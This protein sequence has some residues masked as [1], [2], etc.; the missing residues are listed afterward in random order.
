MRPVD[1]PRTRHCHREQIHLEGVAV[2]VGPLS[3][4]DERVLRRVER[5]MTSLTRSMPM[6]EIKDL[7]PSMQ[8]HVMEVPRAWV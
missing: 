7:P 8:T 4:K 5:N 6:E 1:F 2:E 3:S